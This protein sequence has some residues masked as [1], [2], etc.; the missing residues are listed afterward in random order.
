MDKKFL[1]GF[2]RAMTTADA[3]RTVCCAATDGDKEELD[4]RI[5]ESPSLN[6]VNSPPMKRSPACES[7]FCTGAAKQPNELNIESYPNKM[8]SVGTTTTEMTSDVARRHPCQL[9]RHRCVHQQTH[10]EEENHQSSFQ[11]SASTLMEQIRSIPRVTSKSRQPSSREGTHNV[12]GE[13]DHPGSRRCRR[14]QKRL[15]EQQVLFLYQ[16]NEKNYETKR[17]LAVCSQDLSSFDTRTGSTQ[18]DSHLLVAPSFAT[19][20]GR[21]RGPAK[22]AVP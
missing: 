6:N 16:N 22:A 9:Q 8:P 18:Y 11:S 14:H 17:E 2:A 15:Q 4:T 19:A 10:L 5:W 3:A 7:S 13:E 1:E 21:T 20:I 12:G